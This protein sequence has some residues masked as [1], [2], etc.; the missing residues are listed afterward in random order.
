MRIPDEML[1]SVVFVF[2]S[3]DAARATSADGATGFVVEIQ[4]PLRPA[5][6]R[7][8]VTCQHVVQDQDVYVRFNARDRRGLI[9]HCISQRHWHAHPNGDDI[10]VALVD[11]DLS[12]STVRAIPWPNG[13][14][15]R[16]AVRSWNVGIGDDVFMLGRFLAHSAALR[17]QPI[18][19]FGHIAMM[20]DEP[21]HDGR[22]LKV[23]AYLVEM[24][25]RS[26]FSGSPVVVHMPAGSYRGDGRMIPFYQQN[27]TL[28]G[29]D[30]G[31]KELRPGEHTGMSIVTPAWKIHE[32]LENAGVSGVL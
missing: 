22:G 12:S 29:M 30:V 25:S 27:F 23:E 31:H 32:A 24:L 11:A 6:T 4:A 9:V 14:A 13:V 15:T 16:K 26:G 21:V 8:V 2:R 20:P 18:A 17:N 1:E 3:E 5:G 10:S 7:Y 28:L 19:R